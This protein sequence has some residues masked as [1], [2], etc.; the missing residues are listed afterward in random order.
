MRRSEAVAFYRHYMAACNAHAFDRL[1]D[2]VAE[3]VRVND[4]R[5]GLTA[6]VAG[7]RKV[8]RAFPDYHWEIRGLLVDGD[9]I[10][11][12]FVDTGTHL[13]E[14]MGVPATGRKVTVRE[15]AVY[16]LKDDRL[17]EVWVVAD[18]LTLLDQIR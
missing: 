12:H 7:L 10:A 17:A 4:E 18:N 1:P 6:Y 11:A 16:R 14:F 9:S 13:G 8:V 5:Q 15:F 3:D 2:F